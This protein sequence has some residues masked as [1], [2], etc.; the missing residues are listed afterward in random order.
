MASRKHS[1]DRTNY[2]L[3][4]PTGDNQAIHTTDI[5]EAFELWSADTNWL[6]HSYNPIEHFADDMSDEFH[7]RL[8]G[9]RIEARSMHRH[10]NS[11]RVA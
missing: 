1:Q 11:L 7:E 5:E 6:A 4:D 8:E 10:Y 2:I 9:E 3:I